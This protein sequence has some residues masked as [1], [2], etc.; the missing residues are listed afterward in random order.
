[1][2]APIKGVAVE[3]PALAVVPV[4]IAASEEVH[5]LAIQI[6]ELGETLSQ[7]CGTSMSPSLCQQLQSFDTLSQRA[8][9]Y[10]RLLRGV[11][12]LLAG[13]VEDEQDYI[14]SLVEAIPFE[15]DRQRLAYAAG[16]TTDMPEPHAYCSG[17]PEWL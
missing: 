3:A 4:M 17:D 10:A 13:E 15:R 11:A 7:N 16:L 5:L 8:I 12:Q 9:A 6:T 14:R 1:M 2:R